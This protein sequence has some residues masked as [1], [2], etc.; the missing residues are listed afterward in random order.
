MRT[1]RDYQLAFCDAVET[2]WQ[3]HRSTLGVLPTGCG[4]TVCFAEVV[5]RRASMGRALVIAHR[6]ELITQAKEKIESWAGLDCEVEMGD[7]VA[8][9]NLF[10]SMPV[11]IA[12]VQTLISGGKKKRMERFN[13]MDFSTL[14]VDEFHHCFPR[15]T[16]IGDRRIETIRIGDIVDSY[17]HASGG[18]ERKKVTRLFRNPCPSLVRVRFSDGRQLICTPNHPVFTQ[19]GYRRALTLDESCLVFTNHAL[20]NTDS[21][22]S[23]LRQEISGQKPVWSAVFSNMLLASMQGRVESRASEKS[24]DAVRALRYKYDMPRANRTGAREVGPGLLQRK[25]QVG[26]CAQAELVPNGSDKSDARIK[27]HDA[28]KSIKTPGGGSEN[29]S[30][31]AGLHIL[32]S[33]RERAANKTA[34]R[35]G[36]R[37]GLSDGTP[38]RNSASERSVPMFA[39]CLQSGLGL[40]TIEARD[41]D[42][43][44]ITQDD[45]MDFDRSAEDEGLK[46]ARVDSVEILERGSNGRFGGMCEDGFVYNFEVEGNNNYFASG[47]LVHN[48]TADSYRR[49]LDYFLGGNPE[50]KVLGVTATP[51]RAD[52]A[53]LGQVCESVAYD[54]QII[55]A[56]HDGWLVP[57]EQQFVSIAGLD[58]SGVRTTAGDLNG[59]DLAKI[60]EDEKLMH[61]QCAATLEIIGNRQAIFFASSVR[62]AEMAR[63]IFNRHRE[64][65]ADFVCGATDKEARRK[66]MK[67]VQDGRTQ[68]LCNVGV[69]TEGFDAP[70]IECIIMGRPT[71]SRSLYSQ[72]AGR[73]TRPFPGCVDGPQ[74][75]DARKQAIADSPKKACLI[76]DFV[77]N[78]GRHKLMTT[79]DILGGKYTDEEKT[80]AEEIIKRDGGRRISDVLQEASEEL[81]EQ[82]RQEAEERRRKDEARRMR[83][84]AGVS[85]KAH[86][87]NPF[88]AWGVTPSKSDWNPSG[89]AISEKQREMI[90][91]QGIDPDALSYRDAKNLLNEMFRRMNENICSPKMQSIMVKNGYSENTP[92]DVAGKI[93]DS[94][95]NNG[96]KRPFNDPFAQYLHKAEPPKPAQEDWL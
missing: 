23:E 66:T 60:M 54:Y 13:P 61:G 39:E 5:R 80:L 45:S 42:R 26:I 67:A 31:E 38:N 2:K 9:A 6:Q 37:V 33:R 71:K 10:T 55:D 4:K 36:W 34:N 87:V 70:G 51:D 65:I 74:T 14:V 50:L 49:T 3:Q 85:F 57:V 12:T 72:M 88:D 76:V 78:S 19:N 8:S 58:F 81:I 75:A 94:L 28:A 35:D 47:I 18:I 91:K 64:G 62:H 48:C 84:V 59:A 7:Q 53:A 41:R 92:R 73:A 25:L 29:I 63:E 69:A 22:L 89:K 43:R 15:G 16:M 44:E 24:N 95:K 79:L 30:S 86:S 83:L 46:C 40:R 27:T 20:Q 77:G 32:E 56:I 11:V 96:W 17:N 93:I 90:R 52:E 68:I 21:N 1:L 82:R